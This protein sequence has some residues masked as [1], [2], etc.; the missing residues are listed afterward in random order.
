MVGVPAAHSSSNIA[1]LIST[2][3]AAAPPA[4]DAE[5]TL[6]PDLDKR[7]ESHFVGVG[8]MS[9]LT[10]DEMDKTELASETLSFRQVSRDQRL[11]AFFVK[12]PSLMYERPNDLVKDRQAYDAI[13]R[14]CQPLV[15]DVTSESINLSVR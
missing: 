3:S 5:H 6:D 14:D 7:E 4:P 10:L 11:P 9:G 13:C 12:H 2:G 15:H 1:R 8:A